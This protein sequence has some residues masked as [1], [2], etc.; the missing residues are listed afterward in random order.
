MTFREVRR[1]ALSAIHSDIKKVARRPPCQI[2]G[3][4]VSGL[5]LA[6]LTPRLPSWYLPSYHKTYTDTRAILHRGEKAAVFAE[7]V[8]PVDSL[9]K[10]ELWPQA[11][12][13]A[14]DGN[15]S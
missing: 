7:Q 11:G 5:R 4:T 10:I 9:D 6:N 2:E 12:R 15:R 14:C 3:K 13:T 8:L 1:H